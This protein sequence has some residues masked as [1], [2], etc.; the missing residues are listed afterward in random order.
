VLTYNILVATFNRSELEH[1][2]RYVP[3][4]QS[5]VGDKNLSWMIE[6]GLELP[7]FAFHVDLDE[8]N[9]VMNSWSYL[10]TLVG[11]WE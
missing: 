9:Q 2:E 5:A 8:R 3:L 4:G 11:D 6:N 1:Y 10:D 7:S